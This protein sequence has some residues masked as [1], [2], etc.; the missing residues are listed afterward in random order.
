METRKINYNKIMYIQIY[1]IMRKREGGE[2]E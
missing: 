1:N 2:K